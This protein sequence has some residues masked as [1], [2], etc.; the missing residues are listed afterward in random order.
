MPQHARAT[1]RNCSRHKSEVGP[2]SWRG[3]CGECGPALQDARLDDLHHHRGPYFKAWRRSMAASVGG[4][5]VD[6]VLDAE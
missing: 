3:Y 1:C 2:I 5:L 4:V 6:D